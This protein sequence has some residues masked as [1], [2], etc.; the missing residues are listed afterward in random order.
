M[1]ADLDQAIHQVREKLS[2]QYDH[3]GKPFHFYLDLNRE[4]RP[5]QPIGDG[6]DGELTGGGETGEADTGGEEGGDSVVV[7]PD[8]LRVH[9]ILRH[10]K[11]MILYGP[12][13][14]GKTYVANQVAQRLIQ[15]QLGASVS[16]ENREEQAIQDLTLH[17]ILALA[18]YRNGPDKSLS[19]PEL[20]RL[21]LVQARFRLS[22]IKNPK[23]TCPP[24]TG[25][26][27]KW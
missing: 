16:T 24:K 17:E 21:P 4:W 19:V 8:V 7:D 27:N 14:T 20:E 23:L 12:P 26:K 9:S 22:P 5:G 1:P 13:G 25:P 18:L 6:D 2:P 10:T 3:D 11:N 15:K